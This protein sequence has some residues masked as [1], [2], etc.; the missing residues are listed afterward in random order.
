MNKL[1]ELETFRPPPVPGRE[2]FPPVVAPG[3]PRCARVELL[4]FPDV[5]P[6]RVP[7]RKTGDAHWITPGG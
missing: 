5:S 3:P 4:G 6:P 2:R 1:I 7:M